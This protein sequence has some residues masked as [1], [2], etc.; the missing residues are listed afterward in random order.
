VTGVG[1]Y[2][3]PV[4]WDPE[5]TLQGENTG[6]HTRELL[7]GEAIIE[8]RRTSY[9]REENIFISRPE[10]CMNKDSMEILKSGN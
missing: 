3:G 7:K 2:T 5:L 10:I 9:C 4:S 8:R 6:L 1:T